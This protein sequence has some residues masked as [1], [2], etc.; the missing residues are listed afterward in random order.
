MRNVIITF[1]LSF[2]STLS[3]GQDIAYGKHNA[4]YLEIYHNYE[5]KVKDYN[6]EHKSIDLTLFLNISYATINYSNTDGH[7]TYVLENASSLKTENDNGKTIYSI[8]YDDNKKLSFY[9]HKDNHIWFT[10][11]IYWPNKNILGNC[12]EYEFP[13]KLIY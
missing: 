8:Y 3:F 1:L 5:S 10:S 2:F 4:I 12:F 6:T 11:V 9:L 13:E 7:R